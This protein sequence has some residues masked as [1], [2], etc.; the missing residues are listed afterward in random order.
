M[1]F[2]AVLC[3]IIYPWL[4]IED[5]IRLDSAGTNF[6]HREICQLIR[7]P[8]FEHLY[9]HQLTSTLT[10]KSFDGD[11]II[12]VLEWM[13][14]REAF[15]ESW[16]PLHINDSMVEALIQLPCPLPA[17]PFIKRINFIV[18]KTISFLSIIHLADTMFCNVECL[19]MDFGSV[20]PDIH[21][22]E[23]SVLTS[24]YVLSKAWSLKSLVLLLPSP[25]KLTEAQSCLFGQLL[26]QLGSTLAILHMNG[27]QNVTPHMLDLLVTYCP[28]VQAVFLGS[29]FSSSLAVSQYCHACE[30][31][32]YLGVI[33]LSTCSSFVVTDNMIIPVLRMA[34]NLTLVDLG[35][36]QVTWA[37]LTEAVQHCPLLVEVNTA[38]ATCRFQLSDNGARTSSL[39]ISDVYS[40]ADSQFV[41]FLAALPCWTSLA[42][43]TAN[44]RSSDWIDV[45]VSQLQQCERICCSVSE[46]SF[47]PFDLP[48][49]VPLFALFPNLNEM[50]LSGVRFDDIETDV[51]IANS[52]G[53]IAVLCPNISSL[54]ITNFTPI[55]RLAN[56][57]VKVLIAKFMKLDSIQLP[58]L[59]WSSL[60]RQVLMNLAAT[61]KVW[62]KVTFPLCLFSAEELIEAVE[63]Y[64]LKVQRLQCG[65]KGSTSV[66]VLKQSPRLYAE[67]IK[68]ELITKQ[69]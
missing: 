14:I 32:P 34:A 60:T 48:S 29:D 8:T 6:I 11:R 1:A 22:L 54:A 67:Y 55:N 44:H 2:L 65:V 16:F 42:L 5:L 13:R 57:H 50:S 21:V 49:M 28:N 12:R 59:A 36:S 41:S 37:C 18:K 38:F 19:Q 45:I 23:D 25:W 51:R 9:K 7:S 10:N 24:L 27:L 30:Q 46:I 61:G 17:Y 26:K 66:C 52:F 3:Q 20:A 64:G 63:Q 69:F 43:A 62:K 4:D 33:D 15:L 56:K 58:G 39:I 40:V 31:L 53:H 68:L 35:S 47:A